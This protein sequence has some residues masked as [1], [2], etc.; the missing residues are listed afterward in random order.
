MFLGFAQE[1][2]SRVRISTQAQKLQHKIMFTTAMYRREKTDILLFKLEMLH[3][4]LK[5]RDLLDRHLEYA[6][7]VCNLNKLDYQKSTRSFYAEL[8]S[9]NKAFEYYGPI[10]DAAGDLSTTLKGCLENWA[11]YYSKLYKDTNRHINVELAH[12]CEF[13]ILGPKNLALLNEDITLH[14]VI[15]AINSLKDYS[16]PGED[17]ILSRDLTLLLHMEQGKTTEDYPESWTI[18]RFL[19]RVISNFWNIGRVPWQLKQTI[20]RPFLKAEDKD[21]TNPDFYRPI[22]L[23]NIVRKVYEQILKTRLQNN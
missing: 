1:K 5:E 7:W 13:P 6:E 10:M 19:W 18:L 9:K 16:T 4:Q 23:L 12:K 3:K 15:H 8:R 17:M 14:E 21:P 20:L 11:S 22:A 2:E